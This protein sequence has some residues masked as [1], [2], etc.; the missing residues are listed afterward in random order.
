MVID[1]WSGFLTKK[2]ADAFAP[3]LFS[4]GNIYSSGIALSASRLWINRSLSSGFTTDNGIIHLTQQECK[5]L[6]IHLIRNIIHLLVSNLSH[7][8]RKQRLNL[9]DIFLCQVFT[10]SVHSVY[11]FL[12][13]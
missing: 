1:G 6:N 7:H 4:K 2:R 8:L 13:N 11:F 5:F 3:A 10:F 9:F 12:F